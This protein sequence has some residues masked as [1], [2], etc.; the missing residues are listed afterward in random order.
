ML[1]HAPSLLPPLGIVAMAVKPLAL[2]LLCTHS[3]PGLGNIFLN[4]TAES[5]MRRGQK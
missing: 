3:Q 4:E 5:V 2:G 1:Q